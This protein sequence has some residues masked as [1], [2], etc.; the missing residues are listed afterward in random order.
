MKIPNHP[1]GLMT[2]I[3]RDVLPCVHRELDKWRKLAERIPNEELRMQALASISAKTFHCEGGSIYGILAGERIEES[4]RFVVAYQTISDYLDNLCDRS[5]SLDPDDFSALHESMRDALTPGASHKDYYRFREDRD[6]GGYLSAL[7]QTCQDVLSQLPHLKRVQ[8]YLH[9]L[10]SYYCD[11][12]VHKHVKVEEREPRLK[13]WFAKYEAKL[14][15][16][17][18]YEFSACAGSTLGVFCLVSYAFQQHLNEE[19]VQKIRYGYFPYVQGLHILLD[20]FIDQEEDRDGGDLNFCFYY[21]R[22]ET[23][24]ERFGHFVQEADKHVRGL[25]NEKFHRLINR[26]LLGIYLSD[27]KV[28]AQHGV[29]KTAKQIIKYGGVI[30]KFFYLN[31][32]WYRSLFS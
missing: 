10:C 29:R 22:S 28:N 24:I 9:E 25:P 13:A 30:S 21:P 7:V 20:Y 4:I 3:Y 14:P 19:D 27:R 5:T 1:V 32:R 26:G 6:D 2:K 17:T 31:G 11:L 12:Q 18:W 16:M 8:Q 23:M 15:E